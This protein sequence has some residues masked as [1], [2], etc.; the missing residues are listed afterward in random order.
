MHTEDFMGVLTLGL[1]MGSILTLLIQA[2]G[3][4][5]VRQATVSSDSER[6]DFATLSSANEQQLREMKRM[7]ER[8]NVLEE[9]A[10]DPGHRTAREIEA[11]RTKDL[12]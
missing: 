11:L 12:V 5:K 1:I 7:Q 6:N 2:Y 10:I 8:L 3:R 9:I 4:R